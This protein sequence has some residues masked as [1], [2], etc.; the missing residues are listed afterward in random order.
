MSPGCLPPHKY[1]SHRQGHQDRHTHH[2]AP[3]AGCLRPRL[4]L[5]SSERRKGTLKAKD[6][7]QP[8]L[9]VTLTQLNTR[10]SEDCLYLN[11]WVPQGQKEVSQNLPVMIWIYGGGFV[12]GSGQGLNFLSDYMYEGEEIATRGNVI[13]VTFNYR[14]GPLGFLSTGDANLPGVLG[15]LGKG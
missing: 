15:A 3:G 11:I 6:F 8:C 4:L 12:I 7:K 14:L 1:P 2:G 13:V 10:G 5:G 9:Q